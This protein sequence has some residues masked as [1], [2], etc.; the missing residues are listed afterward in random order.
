MILAIL[1]LPEGLFL[2]PSFNDGNAAVETVLEFPDKT[3]CAKL[4]K[5]SL[6]GLL[7]ELKCLLRH[8]HSII[9]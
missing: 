1:A 9:N 7:F 5:V 2:K 3:H 8:P 4:L 6:E